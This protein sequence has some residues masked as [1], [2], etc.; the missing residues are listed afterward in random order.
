MPNRKY[1][2]KKYLPPRFS[3]AA[4]LACGANLA[5]LPA[6]VVSADN[7]GF[8]GTL[9]RY[10]VIESCAEGDLMVLDWLAY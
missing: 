6:E 7:N 8:Y 1:E 5:I 4:A 10:A 9:T 2:L 3:A